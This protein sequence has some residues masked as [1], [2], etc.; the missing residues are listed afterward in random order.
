MKPEEQIEITPEM[1]EAVA[2]ALV[3]YGLYW[4]SDAEAVRRLVMGLVQA[5]PVRFP[6]LV[7]SLAQALPRASQK[8]CA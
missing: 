7:A 6:R 1:V 5:E 2:G 8:L 3:G 4:E